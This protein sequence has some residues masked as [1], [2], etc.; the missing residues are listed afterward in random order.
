M[1]HQNGI[2]EKTRSLPVGPHDNPAA[3]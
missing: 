2:E 1:N 3:D